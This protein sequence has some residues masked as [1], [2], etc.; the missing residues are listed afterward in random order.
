MYVMHNFQVFQRLFTLKIDY[1]IK[2]NKFYSAIFSIFYSSYKD[3][4]VEDFSLSDFFL[5]IYK[6]NS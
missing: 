1:L 6:I 4:M 2:N 3:I 5:V